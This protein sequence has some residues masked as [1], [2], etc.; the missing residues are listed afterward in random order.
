MT[1]LTWVVDVVLVGRAAVGMAGGW[2]VALVAAE[3]P[4][5][6]SSALFQWASEHF[7]Q[8][9][10]ASLLGTTGGSFD[11]VLQDHHALL[12]GSEGVYGY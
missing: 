11:V 9:L 4:D 2:S 12:Q 8:F 7:R 3:A 1:L 10:L 5:W 6:E